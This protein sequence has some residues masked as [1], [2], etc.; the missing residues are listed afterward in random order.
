MNR[1]RKGVFITTS[2]FSSDAAE[3]V[4]MIEKKIVLIDGEQLAE[5][6]VEYNRAVTTRQVYEVKAIDT[7][8]FNED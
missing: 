2:R 4:G 6:M 3:F 7:D 1:V 5:L 8:Y